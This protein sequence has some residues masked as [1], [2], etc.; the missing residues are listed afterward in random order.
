[1]NRVKTRRAPRAAA[2][3][4]Q[5]LVVALLPIVVCAALALHFFTASVRQAVPLEND[6]VA[7]WSQIAAF[8]EAGFNTGYF[9]VNERPSAASFSRF[10]PHGPVY[11]VLYGLIARATGWRPYTSPIFGAILLA[12][13]ATFWWIRSRPR[14]P[15]TAALLVASFW[16]LVLYLPTTMQEPLHFALAFV[17]AAL[18]HPLIA[19]D[20]GSSARVMITLAVCVVVAALIRPTWALLYVPA[21]ALATAGA[22]PRVRIGGVIAA[23]AAAVLLYVA[24]AALAAPYPL[25]TGSSLV[26]ALRGAD[27]L[28]FV[29]GLGRRAGPNLVAFLAVSPD[30]VMQ[31]V[32]RYQF[33][34]VMAVAAFRTWRATRAAPADRFAVWFT[35]VTFAGVILVGDVE[36]WRDYRLLG[37]M[38]LCAALVGCASG[39]VWPAWLAAVNIAVTPMAVETFVAR[40]RNRFLADT[41]RIEYF[42]RDVAP[43]LR[44]DPAVSG[45]GNTVLMHVDAY[46]NDLLGMPPGIG[47]ASTLHWDQVRLPMKSRYVLVRAADRNDFP[48]GVRVRPVGETVSGA[49]YENLDWQR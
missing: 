45:W 15:L 1:L 16:P 34:I 36:G 13:A 3:A 44:Y 5:G 21:A 20:N 7:Y 17:F 9:V 26:P 38:L 12:A 31:V 49:L 32:L 39:S 10:G 43:L 48:K 11:P 14:R 23:A 18:V 22:A 2:V 37:P 41:T 25:G 24:F 35:G 30:E 28:P 27:L 47:L 42:R 29:R 33:L 4:A 46:Q 40:H 6:E 19:R 8:R